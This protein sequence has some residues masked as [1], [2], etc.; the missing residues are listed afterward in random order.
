MK[1]A[2]VLMWSYVAVLALVWLRSVARQHRSE[3]I[4]HFLELMAGLVPISC[5]VVILVLIGG[6]V[7]LPSVVGILFVFLPAGVA[8]PGGAKRTRVSMSRPA[9]T[10]PRAA[11]VSVSRR[12]KAMPWESKETSAQSG[13]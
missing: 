9:M 1:F 8:V 4:G 7:G 10:A 5:A 2:S 13:S 6:V 12:A 11:G 3:H